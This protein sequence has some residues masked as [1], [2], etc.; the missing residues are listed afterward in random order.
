MRKAEGDFQHMKNV[1]DIIPCMQKI[2]NTTAIKLTSQE[3]QDCDEDVVK[4]EGPGFIKKYHHFAYEN[5]G[6]LKCQYIRGVGDYQIHRTKQ[7][8]GTEVISYV[9]IF[10]LKAFARGRRSVAFAVIT[11][12][13]KMSLVAVGSNA[14]SVIN[15]TIVIAL[16][17]NWTMICLTPHIFSNAIIA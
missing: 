5:P 11:K 10:T 14:N 8:A 12:S 6:Q 1:D 17:T 3:I 9:P 7:L 13:L 2:K 16:I 4:P 15:G